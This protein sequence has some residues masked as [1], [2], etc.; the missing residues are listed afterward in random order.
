[1]VNDL[2]VADAE[3]IRSMETQDLRAELAAA[4]TW[5][6]QRL[7]HLAA[8]WAELDRR[9]EDLSALRSGLVYYLPLI[10]AGQVAPEAVVQFAGSRTLL[11]AVTALPIDEQRNLAAGE[12]VKLAVKQGDQFTHRMLPAH[13]LT[14][15]QVRQVFGDRAI[16]TEAEQIALLSATAPAYEPK[17]PVRVGDITVDPKA[18]TISFGRAKRKA[19]D[20]I[21]AMKRAGMV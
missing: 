16:R 15:T 5:T 6:A 18:G 10:A 2:V 19:D 7:M 4:L 3:R 20:V 13:A 1:V 21:Q 14:S 17:K 11:R 12:S 8:V 9:G